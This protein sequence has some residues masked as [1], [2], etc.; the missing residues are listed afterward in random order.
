MNSIKNNSQTCDA[1]LNAVGGLHHYGLPYERL[2][3]IKCY[4][5]DT[6]FYC[7]EETFNFILKLEE[8]FQNYFEIVSEQNINLKSFFKDKMKEVLTFHIPDCH[9]L[10][11]VIVNRYLV[12]RLK[13]SSK[14]LHKSKSI[15]SSKSMAAYI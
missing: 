14:K 12:F 8:I 6:L 9:N 13:I 10:K 2:T 11:E 3:K 5:K 15:F 7:N 1:C 4:R